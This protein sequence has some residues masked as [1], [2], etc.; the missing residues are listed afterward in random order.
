MRSRVALLGALLL[1]AGCS[2]DVPPPGQ[3]STAPPSFET[4]AAAPTAAAQPPVPLVPVVDAGLGASAPAAT[5]PAPVRLAVPAVGV[6]LPVDP[7]GVDEAGQMALPDTA[8]RTGWYRFG[9][10]PGSPAG[11]TVIA[12]HVDSWTSGLGQFSRLRDVPP[13]AEVS[14]TTA[15]GAAHRYQVVEVVRVDKRE[16][17]VGQWFDRTGSPRLVLV[18]C[19][20]T[21]DRGTGH[22]RDNVIVTAVPVG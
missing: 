15:D 6:D 12:G 11:A 18:T 17:P 5:A 14:V 4:A 3:L 19:G 22:Y 13:G 9:S 8:E 20:G 1:V 10:A 16:A 2:P 21:F 7:V